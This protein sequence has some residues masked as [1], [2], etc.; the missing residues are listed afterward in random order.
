MSSLSYLV[1]AKSA[2][3]EI[4]T[5]KSSILRYRIRV[6]IFAND[7]Q[8]CSTP[9]IRASAEKDA[10]LAAVSIFFE[11]SI[12]FD[13]SKVPIRHATPSYFT[14][15]HLRREIRERL[16]P[17]PHIDISIHRNLRY[18][19]RIILHK[20]ARAPAGE[21]ASLAP[22]SISPTSIDPTFYHR[23]PTRTSA[24][25]KASLASISIFRYSYG[26]STYP[27]MKY[28]HNRP[29]AIRYVELPIRHSTLSYS[30]HKHLGRQIRQPRS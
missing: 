16:Q 22:I 19:I 18:D 1:H 25:K 12:F 28:R 26:I 6:H 10:S 24:N 30:T 13:V 3:H 14:H 7:T 21:D 23:P 27:G 29:K 17:R 11:V 15:T 2:R 5:F 20:H 9:E 8:R 4:S